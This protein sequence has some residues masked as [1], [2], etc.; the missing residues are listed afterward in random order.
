ALWH[1]SLSPA[2]QKPTLVPATPQAKVTSAAVSHT[3][4][5]S[6]VASKYPLLGAS[7]AG[8]V[9]DLLAKEKTIMVLTRIQQNQGSIQ[10]YFQG[11]GFVGAFKGSITP[12]GHLQF[13]VAVRAGQ[14]TLWFDGDIKVGGDIVGSFEVLLGQG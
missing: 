11:L 10:G 13:K 5:L 7:Y 4:T 1:G 14:S 6:P 3:S 2:P 12:S 9:V 8:T